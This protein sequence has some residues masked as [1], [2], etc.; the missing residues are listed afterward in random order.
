MSEPFADRLS[1][2]TPDAAGLDRDALLFAAGRA[3]ARPGRR[4]MALAAAL[5]V[6]QALT[7]ATLWPGSPGPAPPPVA[8]T[9][10]PAPAPEAPPR[11]G[12]PALWA[13][14]QHQFGPEG[15]PPRPQTV[16]DLMP[17]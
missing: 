9:A 10:P 13:L 5:A 2:F 3:A 14:A 6:S 16:V 17:D 12:I 1:R 15:M 4:W 8:E 7:L 11:E